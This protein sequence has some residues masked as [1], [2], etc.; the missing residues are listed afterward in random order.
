MEFLDRD[1]QRYIESQSMEENDLLK[2]I[3]RETNLSVLKPRM[4]SGHLQGRILSM[5]S[6]MM[7][8]KYVLEIGT[9]TGYS[10]L[11][12]AEGIVPGGK[13]VTIDIN[14]E[15]EDRVKRYFNESP[16]KDLLE[17]K[18]GSADEIIPSLS[19]QWDLIFIDADKINY[20]H[21]YDLLID[22]ITPG[23]FIILDNVLW[24]GK[25]LEKNRKKLDKVTAALL[26]FNQAV[27]DDPKVENVLFPLRDGLMV[28][29]KL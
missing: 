4:L 2:K 28:L 20:Q 8:P 25:V 13:L 19:Y 22:Q 23:T 10:A 26:D 15:L 24:S 16:Y 14:E 17:L 5:L 27:Q 7:K 1:L 6:H 3:D 11:C 29:R 9:F 18:I 12:L 21:Y